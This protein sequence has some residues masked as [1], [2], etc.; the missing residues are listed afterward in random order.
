MIKI[1]DEYSLVIN[2]GFI[3]D[4][5]LGDKMEIFLEGEEIVD[6]YNDGKVLGTLDFIKDSLEVTEI[7]SNFAVCKKF[8]TEKIFQPSP[9]QKALTQS[10]IGLSGISGTTETKIR[11]AKISIDEKEA[12]G[13]RTGDKVIRI[14]DI[15]R[16][17]LSE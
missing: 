4:I 10:V 2:G 14:G 15:A 17:A 1:I 13:R 3:N 6:P 7:Y 11:E 16:I 12:T 5:S 8:V 9:F